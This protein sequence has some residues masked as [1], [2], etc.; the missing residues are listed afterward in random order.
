M[1]M[2][3]QILICEEYLKEACEKVEESLN[4]VAD[5]TLG[6]GINEV[7]HSTTKTFKEKLLELCFK[8]GDK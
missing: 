2:S 1:T 5:S 8:E 7:V 3:K 6:C 4:K